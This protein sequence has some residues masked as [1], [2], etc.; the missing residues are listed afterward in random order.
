MPNSKHRISSF[1]CSLGYNT[2]QQQRSDSTVMRRYGKAGNVPECTQRLNLLI[3]AFVQRFKT[4][5]SFLCFCCLNIATI[6]IASPLS[7]IPYK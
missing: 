3:P 5:F 6:L 7:I 4:S 2:P 1:F